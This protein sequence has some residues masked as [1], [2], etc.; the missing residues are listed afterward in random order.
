M[1]RMQLSTLND[2]ERRSALQE[3]QLLQ[4]L[5]HPNVVAFMDAV[6]KLPG[7][8]EYLAERPDCVDIGT[9]PMLKPK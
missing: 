1:K 7:V 5:T 9:A 3:A 4:K 2:K 8:A 6:A